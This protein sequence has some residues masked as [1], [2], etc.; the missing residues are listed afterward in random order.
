MEKV[1]IAIVKD[2]LNDENQVNETYKCLFDLGYNIELFNNTDDLYGVEHISDIVNFIMNKY[3]T[4]QLDLVLISN[5]KEL[6]FPTF[7]VYNDLF[8]AFVLVLNNSNEKKSVV[9]LLNLFSDL[10]DRFFNE[11]LKGYIYLVNLENNYQQLQSKF[12]YNQ[13]KYFK[14]IS[15]W[16]I[17]TEK[18]PVQSMGKKYIYQGNEYYFVPINSGETKTIKY[19]NSDDTE[20]ID[21]LSVLREIK[22]Q[23]QFLAALLYYVFEAS[24]IKNQKTAYDFIQLFNDEIDSTVAGEVLEI[25]VNGDYF[26]ILDFLTRSNLLNALTKMDVAKQ[27]LLEVI[28]Q[29]LLN[30]YDHI[31]HHFTLLMTSLF[32]VTREGL[33]TYPDY[34]NDRMKI[35]EK[36]VDYYNINISKESKREKD[37]R[38]ESKRIAIV[39]TQL[40][41]SR[42][43]PS[44]LVKTI[45]KA[46][47]QEG[48]EIKI[49]IDDNYVYSEKEHIF[50]NLYSSQ[51]SEYLKE[52]HK[53]ELINLDIPIHYSSTTSSRKERIKTDVKEL[54]VYN[55]DVVYL[56]GNDFS[57]RTW[58]LKDK[59]PV[60]VM[61]MNPEP[62]AFKGA[63]T[64][65]SKHSINHHNEVIKKYNID[66]NRRYQQV[67]H[68]V[69]VPELKKRVGEKLLNIE[70]NIFN[71]VTAGNSLDGDLD[72]EF[73]SIIKDF[74]NNH[75]DVKWVVIGNAKHNLTR[76]ILKNEIERDQV[77]ILPYQTKLLEILVLCQMVLVRSFNQ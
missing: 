4:D 43:S 75:D 7:R 1:A 56:M 45:A 60:V 19:I 9:P 23:P 30:D 71:I 57:M 20:T 51:P 39:A 62:S 28:Y 68:F 66:N 37:G 35:M 26:V 61:Q 72:V 5:M 55:P 41:S 77:M 8:N 6:M 11:K 36:I 13:I 49:F 69:P 52:E 58:I 3:E 70:D 22:N 17:E 50:W 67:R 40:L 73:L 33:S 65:T 74:L 14:M 32:Y 34:I 64:Y 29:H 46:L 27:R 48:Y 44:L 16:S 24:T 10:S 54:D 15:E 53:S 2:H 38:S 42:H 25:L 18:Y 31:D 47:M 76:K 21:L 63:S 59:Y 12:K